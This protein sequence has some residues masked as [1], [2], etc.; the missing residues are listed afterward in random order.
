MITISDEGPGIPESEQER[1]FVRFERAAPTR[2]FGGLG[3]GLYV[4][5]QIVEAHGGEISLAPPQA[6][7]RPVRHP[8]A[9]GSSGAGNAAVSHSVLVV[10]D[11]V[12]IRQALDGD[13]RGARVRRAGR[14]ATGRRRSTSSPGR[15]SCPA[16]SSWI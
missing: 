7:G 13:H 10:E 2:N 11:D 15:P 8:A 6:T 16:S 5:R 14:S 12:D 9:R 3:L 4:A 1:I